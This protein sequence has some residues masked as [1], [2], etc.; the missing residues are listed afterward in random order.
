MSEAGRL[1]T[2]DNAEPGL[3]FWDNVIENSPA[4]CYPEEGFETISTNPCSELPLSALDSC[5]LLLLNLF[6][7]VKEPFTSKAYF[8]YQEF[9][10][11]AK[12]A[13]RMMDDII[14][15]EMEAI[16]RII[17]KIES[18]PESKDIKARELDMWHR[19][20]DNCKYQIT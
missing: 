19:I 3:L 12:I 7:Y 4:D 20:Y 5:R 1:K 13:Q 18:D 2:H 14:D 8:D 15:L 6:G 17:K 10:E 11:D 16:E 9:F